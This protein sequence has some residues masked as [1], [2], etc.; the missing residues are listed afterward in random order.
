M[1]TRRWMCCRWLCVEPRRGQGKLKKLW[2]CATDGVANFVLTLAGWA[3]AEDQRDVW[4][5]TTIGVL[6]V[7]LKDSGK[8][9]GPHN[10]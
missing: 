5:S 2:A 9:G 3:G 8:V 1:A 6:V 7:A 10:A 4:S